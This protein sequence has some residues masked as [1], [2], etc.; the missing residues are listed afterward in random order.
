MALVFSIL[1]DYFVIYFI[2][3]YDLITISVETTDIGK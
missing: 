1:T 3:M 2:N